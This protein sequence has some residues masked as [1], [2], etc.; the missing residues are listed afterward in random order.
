MELDIELP[1]GLLARGT[2]RRSRGRW[3]DG[4]LIRWRE[5]D[6]GPIGGW[7]AF[8]KTPVQG[9][10]RSIQTWSARNNA[11][12]AAIGTHTHLYIATRGGVMHDVTPDG[13]RGGREYAS[14]G[15][16]YG[17][18]A[19]GTGTYG[20]PRTGGAP[21]IPASRW[22]F[23]LA[24]EDL[25]GTLNTDGPIYRW[26]PQANPQKAVPLAGAP[27]ARYVLVTN[28]RIVMALGAQG[29]RRRIAWSD[30][31]D[32]T[33]WTPRADNRA[34]DLDLPTRG[35]PLCALNVGDAVFLL[36]DADSWLLTYQGAGGY[37][38][39]EVSGANGA[40]SAGAAQEV[41]GSVM[42]MG[43][44]GFHTYAGYV[45]PLAC[46]VAERVFSDINRAQTSL[47]S[48]FHNSGFS[49]VTWFYPTAGSPECDAYVTYNYAEG[50]WSLGR[51]DRTAAC[52]VSP[53]AHPLMMGAD[54]VL[55]THE[56]GDRRDGRMPFLRGGPL[57]LG[58]TV[59]TVQ[60]YIPDTQSLGDA[61]LVLH[62][63]FHPRGDERAHGPFDASAKT[64]LRAT[65]REVDVELRFAPDQD[66]RLGI[67]SL[68]VTPRGGR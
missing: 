51:L 15:G 2:K 21:I 18:G 8:G 25:V 30:I 50:H 35:L 37:G 60:G 59:A 12:W 52:D 55:Y 42:W 48:S 38:A 23:G 28:Q 40:V 1:P 49:E 11:I 54:G 27:N 16:G 57:S 66:F 58:R 64:D 20:T 61:D 32:V 22:S 33:D 39:R 62:S 17:A 45:Q 47:V 10:A 4:D 53:F 3:L 26:T 29:V 56:D 7:K 19:Y 68:R 67:P 43:Q 34:G 5:G 6:I 13:F 44:E 24:G 31:E 63:R 36:T 65:G 9:K 14:T 41:D 46:D